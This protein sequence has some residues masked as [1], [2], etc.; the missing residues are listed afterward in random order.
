MKLSEDK[1]LKEITGEY[2]KGMKVFAKREYAEALK[3]FDASIEKYK[4]TEF[5][6]VS[7]IR[8][9]V[10]VY[11]N[12]CHSQ[13]NPVEIKLETDEDYLN[14]GV[15]NLNAGNYDRALELLNELENRKYKDL[16]LDYLLS[17]VYLKK[18]DS[19][20]CLK[21][22]KKCI[23]KDNFFK[24]IAYNEPDFAIMFDLDEFRS[25]VE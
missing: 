18:D 23:K 21:H 25:I 4:D 5:F 20:T 1:Q 14:E 15:F 9:R 11:R 7:G 12:I 2:T 16:Y 19:E 8:T 10:K 22:L 6:S 13:L 3:L 24:I 17:I